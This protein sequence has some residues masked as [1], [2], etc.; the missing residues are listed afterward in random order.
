MKLHP[1]LGNKA[2]LLIQGAV[3]LVVLGLGYA[4]WRL[5]GGVSQTTGAAIVYWLAVMAVA[6][7][8]SWLVRAWQIER[9]QTAFYQNQLRQ[10]SDQR[11]ALERRLEGVIQL[12]ELL[13]DPQNEKDVIEKS[14]QII[15]RIANASGISFM[16]FDEWG[17]PLTPFTH[18][19]FPA[20]VLRAW[21]EHLSTPAI[22]HECQICKRLEAKTGQSCP[23]LESPFQG[24]VRIYCLPVQRGNRLTAMLNLYLPTDQALPDELHDFIKVLVNEMVLA[25]EMNR[26]RNQELS[27]LRQ[28][29]MVPGQADELSTVVTRLLE[30]LTNALEFESG[31]IEFKAS[32]PH[33]HGLRLAH[34]SDAWL[35]S[36]AAD[37]V[38]VKILNTGSPPIGKRVAFQSVEGKREVLTAPC[39]LPD[40]TVIGALILAS[41]C[42]SGLQQRHFALVETVTTQA[43]LLVE[44][45]RQ[46]LNREYQTILQERMRLAREIHDSLAQT[47]AYLKLTAAQ[48]QNHLTQGDLNRLEQALNQNYQALSDAYL[49]TR[50]VIDNLRLVPNQEVTLWLSQLASEFEKTSGLTVTCHFPASVPEIRPEVQSQLLRIVQEAFSNIRKHAQASQVG[51]SVRVWQNEL[52]LEI[53]DNGIG[54]SSEDVPVFSRHGLRGMRERAELIGAEFQIIS[55]PD[56]GTT[57]RLHLPLQSEE[58]LV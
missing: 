15:A 29:Q 14:L 18:G 32:Q 41:G 25:I 27:T 55:Q 30:G 35:T 37:E 7:V 11:Q 57:I 2:P 51:V 20:P 23:L 34:G 45:E 5:V 47:L 12:N 1:G 17:Q 44:N 36:S 22:R 53:S 6:G 52:V 50:Q 4:L 58:T 49:E 46:R 26:L 38:V 13:I 16:P 24:T 8:I 3:F 21:A 54:F 10:L 40:G 48:M 31:R 42:I 43:A 19:A 33:F 28:I 9:R 56:S 39:C